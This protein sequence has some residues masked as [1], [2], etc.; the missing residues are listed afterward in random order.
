MNQFAYRVEQEQNGCYR[1]IGIT[2]D[3]TLLKFYEEIENVMIIRIDLESYEEKVIFPKTKKL[4]RVK[5]DE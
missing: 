2:F 5:I 1:L 4:E 3:E